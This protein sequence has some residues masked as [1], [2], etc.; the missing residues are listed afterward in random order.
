MEQNW[1]GDVVV[2]GA[3]PAGSACA[4]FL[5]RAGL[6]TLVVDRS[7]AEREQRPIEVLSPDTVRLLRRHRFTEAI[8]V[9]SFARCRGVYGLW[10][11]KPEFFDYELHACEAALAV[12]RGQFDKAFQAHALGDGA[13][14][15]SDARIEDAVLTAGE[16]WLLTIQNQ[17]SRIVVRCGL[18]IEA[19]G[20]SGKQFGADT[21]RLYF[22][23]LLAVFCSSSAK[24]GKCQLMRLEAAPEGWWY[25]AADAAGRASV[26]FV[27]DA[28]RFPPTAVERERKFRNMYAKTRLIRSHFPPLTES[29]HLRFIDSRTARRRILA[30]RRLLAIGDAAYSVDPLSGAGIRRAVESGARAALAATQLLGSSAKHALSE[31]AQWAAADFRRWVQNKEAVYS[32]ADLAFAEQEFWRR[33][34]SPHPLTNSTR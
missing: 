27:T 6:K 23:R 10:A 19:T 29:L 15:L 34:L 1:S 12:D 21:G 17:Q 8:S 16:R 18:F 24:P 11:N 26:V 20:R 28:D 4:S 25:A 14:L 31:Y 32:T 5:A 7:G 2:A 3:G 22:D 30:S 33:R 9:E 13:Q